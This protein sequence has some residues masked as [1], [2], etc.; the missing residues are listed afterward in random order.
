MLGF[1]WGGPT[2]QGIETP[3][4]AAFLLELQAV[5]KRLGLGIVPYGDAGLG[6]WM[7]ALDQQCAAGE[8]SP[9][10]A[11]LQALPWPSEAGPSLPPLSQDPFGRYTIINAPWEQ[12][13]AAC[14]TSAWAA[15]GALGR[16]TL[17]PFLWYESSMQ[18][19]RGSG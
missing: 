1:D 18:V 14:N 6:G 10:Q 4:I 5:I 15:N 13:G 9:L 2:T 17:H 7:N 3:V 16:A 19:R 12:F 11:Q 8:C